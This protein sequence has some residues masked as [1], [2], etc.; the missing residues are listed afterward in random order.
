M[1]HNL[2][3][4]LG[5]YAEQNIY[6]IKEYIIKYG[7]EYKDGE[8]YVAAD[9]LKFLFYADDGQLLEAKA[10]VVP[11]GEFT[12]GIEDLYAVELQSCNLQ[13]SENP[14]NA[15]RHFFKQLFSATVN[16]QNRGD[17]YLHVCLHVPLFVEGAWDRAQVL[18][19]AIKETK[20]KYTVDLLL[21]A[22][23]I[24]HLFVEEQVLV[25]RW[26]EIEEYSKQILQQI[27]DVKTGGAYEN[28]LNNL[29]LIEN[30]NQSGLAL[31]LTK[32]AYTNIIGEYALTTA[33]YY[34][35][36]YTPAYQL[37]TSNARPIIGMG[38]SMI[39]FDRFYFVQYMLRK[40]YNY[41]LEREGISDVA[42]DSDKVSP[43]VQKVLRANINILKNIYDNKVKPLMDSKKSIEDILADM[44]DVITA[45][46]ERLKAEFLSLVNKEEWTLPE[47]RVAMAQL[48]GEDDEMLVGSQANLNQLVVDEC[49]RDVLDYFIEKNNLL[50]VMDEEAV[51]SEGNLM[52]DYAVLSRDDEPI[53]TAAAKLNKIKEK[54][55]QIKECT[56]YIRRTHK[57]L[58]MLGNNVV[59]ER[60]SH[61]RL[62]KDGFEFRGQRYYVMPKNIERPLEE[63]F[64]PGTTKLPANVDLRQNFTRVKNQGELGSCTAFAMVSIYEYILKKN[65]KKEVDL[66]ELFAYHIARKRNVE[67]PEEEGT[68]L[69]DVVTGM[70]ESG[71][72]LENLHPYRAADDNEPSPEAYDDAAKRKIAKALNVRCEVNDLKAA[73][74][75]GYPVAISL[76][77]YDSFTTDT[78][79]IHCPTEEERKGD[80]GGHAMVICGY[81]DENKVFIVRNSWGE[82]FGDKG[83]CYIPYSYIGDSS[84]LRGACIITE[85]SIAEL[86]VSGHVEKVAISFNMSDAK[87]H[88]DILKTKIEAEEQ[89]VKTLE[90]ELAVLSRDYLELVTQLGRPQTREA[91]NKGTE[92]R[93]KIEAENLKLRKRELEEERTQQ[94]SEYRDESKWLYIWSGAAA[95]GL[96]VI[97]TLLRLHTDDPSTLEYLSSWGWLNLLQV[98][99]LLALFVA[100]PQLIAKNKKLQLSEERVNK[101]LSQM[102]LMWKVWFGTLFVVVISYIFLS[103]Y[104][105]IEP[106][107]IGGWWQLLLAI[108]TYIPFVSYMLLRKHIEREIKDSYEEKIVDLSTKIDKCTKE[109]KSL[110]MDFHITG[111]ILDS[112]SSLI[113]YLFSKYKN[114]CSYVDNLREWHAE[115]ATME[116]MIPV[117]R[118][119]FMSLTNN[120]CLDNFFKEHA[121]ELT[122]ELHLYELFYNENYDISNERIIEFKNVLKRSLQKTLWHYTEDFSIYDHVTQ[123]RKFDYVDDRY[124][125][126]DSLLQKMDKNSEIFVSTNATFSNIEAQNAKCKLMFREAPGN[127]GFR[128]WDASVE[129]N[130]N[131]RPTSHDLTSP[132][133]VFIIRLEGL[134][135]EEIV[136]LQ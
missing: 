131:N 123:T 32:E 9:Y 97:Y 104:K 21:L 67:N 129:A 72:C 74:A 35:D 13:L 118:D 81:S 2:H 134:S 10:K 50:V 102:D 107:P 1:T 116:E 41:I 43:V 111:K 3:I 63:T 57:E 6:R 61:K 47:K 126:I 135:K 112:L 17:G 114:L 37:A 121:E 90:E 79:F 23:D 48:L 133:K 125:S 69:Y 42:V 26:S 93:L 87:V 53:E 88:S 108:M 28:L 40:S 96:F 99:G 39:H 8:G 92:E 89:C 94:L 115:N 36:I 46:I 65:N 25:S 120:A 52:R 30:R 127:N 58:K 4:L 11:D 105:V 85:V 98:G 29:I 18:M 7:K 64:E 45:E 15:L 101:L 24:A 128:D 80:G 34:N 31:N 5:N 20:A 86:K 44:G 22:P 113:S 49:R 62:T 82:E 95:F 91:L 122:C 70:G 66:S 117:N 136:L 59:E 78:G 27:V 84:M 103:L 83:Y 54:K 76:L 38:M 77:I 12:S 19:N 130:F 100:T 106:F 119:P 71:I 51:D 33:V 55:R 56:D 60:E 14:E 109:R 110:V 73:V 124:L 16:M 68:S 75:Q 132:Y